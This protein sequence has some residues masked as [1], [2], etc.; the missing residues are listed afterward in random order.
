[1]AWLKDMER[2]L[3]QVLAEWR[4]T[5]DTDQRGEIMKRLQVLLSGQQERQATEKVRRRLDAR[6]E[7]TGL[8]PQPGDKVLMRQNNKVG[9]LSERR[10]RKAIVQLGALPLTV[11][12]GDLVAVRDKPS[13]E[14]PAA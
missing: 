11:D 6:Y 2:K 14:P 3:R 4:R 5:R 7:E 8:P 12:Y 13:E 10:G 1:M 9:I